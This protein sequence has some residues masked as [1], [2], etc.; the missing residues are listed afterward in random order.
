MSSVLHISTVVPGRIILKPSFRKFRAPKAEEQYATLA[1]IEFSEEIVHQKKTEENEMS[2]AAT[3]SL[4]VSAFQKS[5]VP[6]KKSVKVDYSKFKITKRSK[7][8]PKCSV[9]DNLI[10]SF[11]QLSL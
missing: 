7:P 9:V 6:E 4:F 11:D 10:T 3:N 2:T 5:P 8:V 1:A